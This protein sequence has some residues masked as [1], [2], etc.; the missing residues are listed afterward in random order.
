[1]G[2][3]QTAKRQAR[4]IA[5]TCACFNLRKASR[6]VTQLYDEALR[7]AGILGTQQP[8][9][10]C[11]RALGPVTVGVLARTLAMDRTTLTRNLAPLLRDGLVSADAGTDRRERVV[12]LTAKGGRTLERTIPLWRRAQRRIVRVLG[13]ERYARLVEDL[14]DVIEA[15]RT[16]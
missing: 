5:S 11:L 16:D 3:S 10:V 2:R 9:L 8:I 4:D 1:M 12:T 15:A 13:R 14:G 6:V 7:P